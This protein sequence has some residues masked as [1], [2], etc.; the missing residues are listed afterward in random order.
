[1]EMDLAVIELVESPHPIRRTAPTNERGTNWAA[2][3]A[4]SGGAVSTF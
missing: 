1:M 3:T 2:R 4:A